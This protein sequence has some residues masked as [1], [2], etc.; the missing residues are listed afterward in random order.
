MSLRRPFL[1]GAI[2]AG[3]MVAGWL[4]A[5]FEPIPAIA[6]AKPGKTEKARGQPSSGFTLKVPVEVVVV[7][8]I[9]TDRDGN[10]I[11]DLTE[12]DFEVYENRK[13]QTIQS[14][15]QEIYQ[16]PQSSMTWGSQAG[17]EEPAPEAAP[18]KPR[19]LSLV[20]DDLTYPPMGTLNRTV[21][22]IRGFVE[23]G[24]KE[25][26]YISIMTASRGY[27]VPF[28]QDREL[29]LAEIDQLHNNLDFTQ[30][31]RRQGCVTMTDAQAEEIEVFAPMPGN[32][33]LD[34]AMAEAEA[35]GVGAGPDAP[36]VQI[37][38]AG[39][40]G[41]PIDPTQQMVENYVRTLASQHLAGQRSRIR[42]L[43]DVLRAHIRSLG[44]V[45][46]QKSLVLLSGGF[47]HRAL[48]YDLERLVDMALKTGIIFNTIR[49]IGLETSPMYDVS[50]EITN[51][52]GL[53]LDKS[54]L[55]SE[56]RKQK[57][58]SLEYLARATGGIYFR[59]N[60]DLVAGLRQVVDQQFSYYVLSYA[61]PPRSPTAAT[62]SF[63]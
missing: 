54:L 34:V 44:P 25:Q 32:R 38:G 3:T 37:Q 31:L 5:A 1:T 4:T 49:A 22:A 7:N 52:S 46:A 43:L 36:Q 62:T 57:G 53:R 39:I 10:P 8:A 29:L 28:T 51:N 45:E 50:D 42:R 47:L 6:E 17:E 19:L 33:A 30:A 61:T 2:L 35:C 56:D 48:R 55:V 40:G 58:M 24:L 16:N 18:D 13:K 60:N 26:N 21:E 15:S 41:S 20:I 14:F 27:F 59:D 11:T 23:R 12:S 63:E 9:V